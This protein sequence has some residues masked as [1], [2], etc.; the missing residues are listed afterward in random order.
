[1]DNLVLVG[2]SCSG[3]TTIGRTL[4][5]RLHLRFVDSDRLVETTAGR[6]IPQIFAEEGEPAFR[7]FER[8]AIAE[9]CASSQ[10]VVSTGGGA[11]VDPENRARLS[12]GNFVVHLQVRPSTVIQRL[13]GS[14]TGRLRPLLDAPDP[15]ARVTELM[16]SRRDAY[17]QAHVTLVVDGRSTY[18]LVREITRRWLARQR[19]SQREAAGT[20]PR[21]LA[22]PGQG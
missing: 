18:E 9:V 16:A 3:K 6:T 2:F 20:T 15:L 17:A 22:L 5:R 8:E 1:M 12:D 13:R 14:R 19:G 4:A 21:V 7:A 11:F 10:Q